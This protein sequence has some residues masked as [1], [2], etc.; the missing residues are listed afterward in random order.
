MH[1]GLTTTRPRLIRAAVFLGFA[2]AIAATIW[3][4]VM[5]FGNDVPVG[6]R[7]RDDR[8]LMLG[9]FALAFAGL[10]AVPGAVLT[11]AFLRWR[12]AWL[13]KSYDTVFFLLVVANLLI[14]S[15][16][17]PYVMFEFCWACDLE[18]WWMQTTVPASVFVAIAPL[19]WSALSPRIA[20]LP[21]DYHPEA[22]FL[23]VW[24][25][26]CF[27]S[28]RTAHANLERRRGSPLRPGQF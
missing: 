27:L 2:A 19:V 11:V 14:F 15:T 12:R 25:S 16:G 18:S 6:R 4:M 3:M 23:R 7:M 24:R 10:L 9:V 22:G 20:S 28:R 21:N 8:Q 13:R 5:N 26:L 1:L 17:A